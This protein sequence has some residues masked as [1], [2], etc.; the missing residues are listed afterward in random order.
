MKTRLLILILMGPLCSLAAEM[1]IWQDK[2]NRP[3]ICALTVPEL[4][5]R[6]LAELDDKQEVDTAF[7][8]YVDD[9]TTNVAVDRSIADQAVLLRESSASRL[10]LVDACIAAC[11]KQHRCMLVHRD[12]HMDALPGTVLQMRLPDKA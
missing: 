5:T 7:K 10:P 4:K 11:A 2:K 12:P 8:R 1:R 9:L 3:A 6:L